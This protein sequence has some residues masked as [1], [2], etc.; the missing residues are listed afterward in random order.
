M[1]KRT[2]ARTDLWGTPFLQRHSFLCHPLL[3]VRVKLQFKLHDHAYHV[4]VWNHVKQL[5][6]ETM[7]PYSRAIQLAA[8]GPELAHQSTWTR[9]RTS[10][11][12]I[13]TSNSHLTHTVCVSMQI[14]C[15]CFTDLFFLSQCI[16]TCF[17]SLIAANTPNFCFQFVF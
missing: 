9:F 8:R 11:M 1:L 14:K 17:S 15:N 7:M 3:V 4:P 13:L 16:S 6:G 12:L 10:P 2:G 5:A